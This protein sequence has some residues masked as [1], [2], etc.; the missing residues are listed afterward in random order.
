MKAATHAVDCDGICSAAL[1]KMKFPEIEIHFT[2]PEDIMKSEER[3]DIV[4]DLPKP[5]NAKV[6]IDHHISNY[7]RLVREGRLE[8][9]DMIDPEAPSSAQLLIDYLKLRGNKIAEELVKIANISDTG[10]YDKTVLALDKLIK[11]SVDD[12]D[13]LE[14]LVEALTE[15]GAS[16]LL[17]EDVKKRWENI[18][19]N[20]EKFIGRIKNLI[21]D[22]PKAEFYFLDEVDS[23]PYYA[24]KDAW[25]ILHEL[26]AKVAVI[27]YR[28]PVKKDK[29]K[30]SLRVSEDFNFDARKF[31]EKFGGGGHKKAA[32][33]NLDE[34]ALMIDLLRELG[35]LSSFVY[36]RL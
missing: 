24:A 34:G 28:N 29:I 30:V 31:A 25:Y 20:Y 17:D 10:K 27:V 23:I 6:N 32:G 19:E 22:A 15:Y 2:T 16:F 1:L 12:R 7:E 5:K 13:F 36:I 8:E 4:V 35:K 14:K 3:F 26:G 21:M 11:S 33:M 18:R 9:C